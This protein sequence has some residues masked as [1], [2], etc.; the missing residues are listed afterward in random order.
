MMMVGS[1]SAAIMLTNAVYSF[2]QVNGLVP[3]LA[4]DR[5]ALESAVEE[6]LRYRSSTL[7]LP[8]VATTDV[9]IGGKQIAAGDRLTLWVASANRDEAVF[10]DPDSFVHDRNP[11]EH[12]AFGKGIH[13]CIGTRVARM[14][15]RIV[16]S[17]LFARLADL[18]LREGELEPRINPVELGFESL[19]IRFE[20]QPTRS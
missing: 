16:L 19:P 1:T 7:A 5:D 12:L 17:M 10:E 8:R 3:K 14:E 6:S 20:G 11:D 9:E 4:D 18:E 2:Q 13:Y 15:A